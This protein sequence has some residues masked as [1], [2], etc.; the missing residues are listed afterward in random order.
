MHDVR[1]YVRMYVCF[2]TVCCLHTFHVQDI[3]QRNL[4]RQKE[5]ITQT[6]VVAGREFKARR[7]GRKGRC[8][9]NGGKYIRMWPVSDCQPVVQYMSPPPNPTAMLLCCSSPCPCVGACIQE[10]PRRGGV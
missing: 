4:Q 1:M 3:L 5:T 8:R 9:V 6:Q 10:H 7:G 2:C